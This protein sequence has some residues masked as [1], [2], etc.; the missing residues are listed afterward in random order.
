MFI[1]K[2][3][4]IGL[5]GMS[6]CCG[7]GLF[8]TEQLTDMV[9]GLLPEEFAQ[10]QAVLEAAMA[11]AEAEIEAAQT[12]VE[13]DED[14]VAE[15]PVVAEEAPA[16]VDELPEQS[17]D[18]ATTEQP[19]V[20]EVPPT[21]G[22]G[23]GVV[24]PSLTVEQASYEARQHIRVF[25]T[26]PYYASESG[27]WVGLFS[28]DVPHGSELDAD[29]QQF[30]YDYVN[31]RP[32]GEIIFTA[33][34]T[35]GTYDVR[36]FDDD[37][38][39]QEVVAS[40]AFTVVDSAPKAL[41]IIPGKTNYARGEPIDF[42]YTTPPD[43]SFSAWFALVPSDT[44]HNDE[45]AANEFYLD[46]VYTDGAVAGQ[47]ELQ[48]IQQPGSYDLRLYPSDGTDSEAAS[49]TITVDEV[50]A[51]SLTTDKTTYETGEQIRISFAAPYY[52]YDDYAWLGLFPAEL[53]HTDEAEADG[54]QYD[55]AYVDEQSGGEMIFSAPTE[56]GSYDF[57]LFDNDE[58]GQEVV[59]S[60]PFMVVEGAPQAANLQ[61]EKDTF[62][63]GEE[64]TISFTTP[65]DFWGAWIGLVPAEVPHGDEQT[66]DEY[67][68]NY[69]F[70]GGATR[71][72]LTMETPL[73]PGTYDFR[74]YPGD[75]SEAASVTF[76]V[77]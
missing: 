64:V 61:L 42:T 53:P 24:Q 58:G 71:G 44:P 60:T 70:T 36:L 67:D 20:N 55:Y 74:L 3:L 29:G 63:R 35:P 27:A 32:E 33:P 10:Q 45:A 11:T 46:Y 54:Q 25:F 56:P 65:P 73:R 22:G 14:A 34:E 77:Q 75:G 16:E 17:D 26:A 50:A 69:E 68:I 37:S 41:S 2:W 1:Q 38:G 31:E 40:Q 9:S 8:D 51:P 4:I 13:A 18:S 43:F 23:P 52:S 30:A 28:A 12:G 6:L 19:A 21:A 7:C 72:T 5:L 62:G 48:G 57:R 66:G 49:V 76:I 59:A 15:G 39:G 47:F